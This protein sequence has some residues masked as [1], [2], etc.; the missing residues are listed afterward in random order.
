MF[1]KIMVVC[2]GNICRSPMAEA[3]LR[4]GLRAKEGGGHEV[5]S[6]GLGAMV[7][8]PADEMAQALLWEQGI[9]ISEHMAKQ[10]NSDLIHWS[11]VILV[12]DQEQRRAIEV[13]EPSAR[14]RVYRLGEWGDFDVPDPYRRSEKVFRQVFELVSRGVSE[15]IPKLT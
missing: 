1:Q 14:G 12:M 8:H 13:S 10:L 11:D 6:A 4:E 7:G 15:W 2:I 3:L 9:D 5:Q